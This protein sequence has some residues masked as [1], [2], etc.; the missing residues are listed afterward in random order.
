[1]TASLRRH[2]LGGAVIVVVAVLAATRSQPGA[3]A[4]PGHRAS[5]FRQAA[6][7]DAANLRLAAQAVQ[8][9]ALASG[10]LRHPTRSRRPAVVLFRADEALI[11]A[12]LRRDP[13]RRPRDTRAVMGPV[14]YNLRHPE[15]HRPP[16]AN[17][18]GTRALRRFTGSVPVAGSAGIGAHTR[19]RGARPAPYQHP[20][21]R[22]VDPRLPRAGRH[23][24]IS[25]VALRS[26]LRELGQPYVWGGAGPTTFDCS[27][28]VMRSYGRAGIRLVHF[29]RTQWNE[30]RLIPARD[31]LPGDLVLF[32]HPIFHVAI[33]LGAGWMLNAPFTGHYVDVV[34]VWKHVAGVVR[35]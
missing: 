35:P 18:R 27:G 15:R 26:A 22:Y 21:G 4:E 3:G 29:S 32:G 8:A 14:P 10:A 19:F 20:D 30:G 13:S 24:T 2:A 12:A 31:A 23:P 7:L 11:A 6:A 17:I 1:M 33:Y 16:H 34:P 28:L 9:Q 25:E 5:H